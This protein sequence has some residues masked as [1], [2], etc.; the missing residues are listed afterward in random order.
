MTVDL[1][2]WII[3]LS[4]IANLG[5]TAAL[6]KR[7]GWLALPK[8]WMRLLFLANFTWVAATIWIVHHR[9]GE[10]ASFRHMLLG[11]ASL[12]EFV[13]LAGLFHWYGTPQGREHAARMLNGPV[14]ETDST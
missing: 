3:I 9:L 7:V 11:A 5:V 13:A 14:R 10:D 8:T 2:R 6:F 1:V 4:C 12:M